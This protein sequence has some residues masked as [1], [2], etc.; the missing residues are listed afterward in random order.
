LIA[1]LAVFAVVAAAASALPAPESAPGD[2]LDPRTYAPES[3][4]FL[5][6]H[7]TG[8]QKYTCR[9]DG[10]WLFAGPEA[11]LHQT[12]GAATPIGAHF[13]NFG[14]GRP[15]WQLQD[16]SSVEAVR[17][18]SASAG[19]GNIAW[20]LLKAVATTAGADGHRLTATTWVQRLNTSGGVAPD[21]TCTP[22]ATIAVPYTADYFFWRAADEGNA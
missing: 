8:A 7:A 18:A 20:L 10:T 17:W 4:L 2:A 11:I 3:V 1:V 13:L 14:T 15:V 16:G 21:G 12:T 6:T 5:V 22:G 19:A 9:A